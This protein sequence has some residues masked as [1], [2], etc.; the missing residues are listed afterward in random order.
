[1]MLFEIVNFDIR[2]EVENKTIA[3]D[4][5]LRSYRERHHVI[6]SSRENIKK[7]G[8]VAKLSL[9]A[10]KALEEIH[11]SFR[12]YKAL[13]SLLN[14]IV[15]VDFSNKG[16]INNEEINSQSIIHMSYD[17]FTQSARVQPTTLITENDVD[18]KMYEQIIKGYLKSNSD[19]S[20]LNFYFQKHCGYGSHTYKV[21]SDYKNELKF[22]FCI[23]DS[24][25]KYPFA[26][27]GSTA[28][29]FK[30][31]DFGVRGT[32]E[33]RML[34]VRELE[35]LIPI[36]VIEKLTVEG[37]YSDTSIDILDKI[38]A[39]DNE[40]DYSFRTY[41]DHKDGISLKEAIKPNNKFFWKKFFRNEH[42]VIIKD[43]FKTD[44]CVECGSCIKIK[45]FGEKTLEKS[46][47]LLE[48]SNVRSIIKK[49]APN[50]KSEW[51][52]IGAKAIS[53]GCVPS[54]RRERA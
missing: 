21:F 3:L 43:C 54:G 1:M 9:E 19:L 6:V 48:T 41:F 8:N 37:D 45:G 7:M 28:G 24:D 27:L 50:I 14:V 23:V 2:D 39:L 13:S 10:E 32:T 42:G 46:V 35:S 18:H 15:K 25:Q 22:A 29:K 34:L 33:A 38:K 31:E 52:I 12:E 53:W 49:L 4:N 16:I 36:E 11:D 17:Y 20:G 26:P 47:E 44:N 40:S 51:D 30:K 5:I